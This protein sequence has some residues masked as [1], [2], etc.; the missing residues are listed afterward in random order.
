VYAAVV[1]SAFQLFV[2]FY[3]E[4]TLRRLFGGEYERYCAEVPRWLPRVPRPSR[5]R[6]G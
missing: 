6:T 1:W 2:T 5:P 4:P 3:E